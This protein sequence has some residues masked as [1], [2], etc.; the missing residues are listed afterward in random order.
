MTLKLIFVTLPL[1]VDVIWILH[2]QNKIEK[3]KE[4]GK[5]LQKMLHGHGT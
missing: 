1:F 3:I 4:D 5:H 2:S